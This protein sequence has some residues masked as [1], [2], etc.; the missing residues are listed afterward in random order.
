MQVIFNIQPAHISFLCLRW[1]V[2]RTDAGTWEMHRTRR[3]LHLTGLNIEGPIQ[4]VT[5]DELRANLAALST[6]M[7]VPKS[8]L[9]SLL[10][11]N[12][13]TQP[14]VSFKTEPLLACNLFV[15]TDMESSLTNLLSSTISSE[16]TRMSLPS[17]TIATTS[18]IWLNS[19]T[20]WREKPPFTSRPNCSS[21]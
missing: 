8:E 16:P 1:L 7:G 4:Q 2:R 9:R 10:D 6:E 18:K 12:E 3:D 13:L 20:N 11:D 5:K 17:S 21:I 14:K 15:D 19:S